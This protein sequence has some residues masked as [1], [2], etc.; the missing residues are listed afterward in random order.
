MSSDADLNNLLGMARTAELGGNSQEATNYYNRVLEIDPSV[1]EAWIG[2]GKAAGWQS[3]LVNFRLPEMIVAFTNAIGSAP[4]EAKEA[5]AKQVVDEANKIVVALYGLARKH[6][7]DFASLDGTWPAYLIQIG[8]LLDTMEEVRT[9]LPANRD[10]LENIVYFC[11]DNIE[12]YSFRDQFNN[13]MPGAYGITPQYEQLL[14]TK[15]ESAAS[16]LTALDP[17]YAPPAIEKKSA[18]ACFVVTATM[19]DFNHPNVTLL[20][21]FRDDWILKRPW[22]ERF[23]SCYYQI[24]PKV[25]DVISPRPVLRRLSYRCLVLPASW[26]ANRLLR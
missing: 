23:V 17:S 10:T 1:Y 21:R 12:G 18:D 2:K 7:V 14:R 3:S 13:N 25:A 24:G 16:A 26:V 9:W 5:V 8:Q 15:L 19:G 20:R 6:L 4:P 11:K 22:G